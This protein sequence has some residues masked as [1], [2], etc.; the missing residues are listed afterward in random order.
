[1]WARRC[2]SLREYSFRC[3]FADLVRTSD[4]KRE[5]TKEVVRN[6]MIATIFRGSYTRIEKIGGAKK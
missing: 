2:P 5:I 4:T 3:S 6:A 1:M